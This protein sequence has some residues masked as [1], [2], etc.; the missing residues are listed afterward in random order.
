MGTIVFMSEACGLWFLRAIAAKNCASDGY[1]QFPSAPLGIEEMSRSVD[2][3]GPAFGTEGE[4]R[5]LVKSSDQ[6]DRVL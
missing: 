1:T 3:L 5:F 4:R 2:K 6:D